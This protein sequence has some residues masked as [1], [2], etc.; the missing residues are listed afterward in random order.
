VG[1]GFAGRIKMLSTVIQMRRHGTEIYIL[2]KFLPSL[3][4]TKN[5]GRERGGAEGRFVRSG[6]RKGCV[7]GGENVKLE[8]EGRRKG[9]ND[10]S[11]EERG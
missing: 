8:W 5:R 1:R 7:G 4:G 10:R 3:N 2:P 11:G 9:D 6:E